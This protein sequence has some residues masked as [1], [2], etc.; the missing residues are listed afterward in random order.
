[1]MTVIELPGG[2]YRIYAKGASEII[3]SRLVCPIIYVG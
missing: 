3:L 2:G 1:M